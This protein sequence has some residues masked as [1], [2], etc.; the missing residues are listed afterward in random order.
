MISTADEIVG[1]LSVGNRQRVEILRALSH[2]ARVL[3][4]DEPTA[5]LTESRRARLFDI[6]RRLKRRGVGIVYISHRMDEIFEIADRVTV[7]RDGAYVGTREGRRHQRRRTGAND[8]RPADRHSL[9]EDRGRRSAPRC[10][11]RAISC[12]KPD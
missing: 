4:M 5:A 8:G 1:A 11:K 10:S 12:A 3:I 2:D 9:S 7:L 6:V